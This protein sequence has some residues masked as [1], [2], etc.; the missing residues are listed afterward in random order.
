MPR[1]DEARE[2]WAEPVAIY[3][4][5]LGEDFDRSHHDLA[6]ALR[7]HSDSLLKA[8]Y[9]DEAQAAIA[10]AT[11]I[12][13][14]LH[15][16]T[17]EQWGQGHLAGALRIYAL[18]FSKVGLIGDACAAWEEPIALYRALS[19]ESLSQHQFEFTRALREYRSDLHSASRF[20][21]ASAASAELV[22]VFRSLH[23]RHPTLYANNLAWAL[24]LL[25]ES[26]SKATRLDGACDAY[27]EAVVLYRALYERERMYG[28]TLVPA[29][30]DYACA[31]FEAGRVRG[32][33]DL[34]AA[35]DAVQ[36]ARKIDWL[37]A[38]PGRLRTALRDLGK[39]AVQHGKYGLALDAIV[40]A[41]RLASPDAE[42][43]SKVL[44]E[45]LRELESECRLKLSQLQQSE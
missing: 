32:E 35:R 34:E 13:R 16:Q 23:T 11:E 19:A 17:P 12:H 33:A 31:L 15:T 25:G 21:D 40:Q 29:L 2:A 3:R 1:V 24:S 36:L 41:T 8:G 39:A 38:K 27:A 7:M 9:L 18:F 5:L 43:E 45:D 28:P 22:S 42:R 4:R 6:S 20:E 30:A 37:T 10:E 44:E 26:L 14:A